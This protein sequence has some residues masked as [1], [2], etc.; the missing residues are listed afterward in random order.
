ME[1]EVLAE[2]P[3][4]NAFMNVKVDP[5]LVVNKAT[6]DAPVIIRFVLDIAEQA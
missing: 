2:D 6:F 5:P 4:L 3:E 1:A